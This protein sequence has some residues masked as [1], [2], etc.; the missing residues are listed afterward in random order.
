[1]LFNAV[2]IAILIAYVNARIS[3]SEAKIEA[4]FESVNQRFDSINQRFDDVRDLWRNN[5]TGSRK[6]WTHVSDTSRKSAVKNPTFKAIQLTTVRPCLT[7]S[8]RSQVS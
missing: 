7:A 8:Q 1:M 6:C 2:L 3:G 5:S 4:R